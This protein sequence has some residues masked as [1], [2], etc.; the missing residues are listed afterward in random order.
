MAIE[1]LGDDGVIAGHF[2]TQLVCVRTFRRNR[3][4]ALWLVLLRL[5]PFLLGLPLLSE[6]A[7]ELCFLTQLVL[8]LTLLLGLVTFSQDAHLT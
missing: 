5:C 4:F 8:S 2:E 3:L 7:F 6:F 1:G